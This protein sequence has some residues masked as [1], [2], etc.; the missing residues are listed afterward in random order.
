MRRAIAQAALLAA[1]CATAANAGGHFMPMRHPGSNAQTGATATNP[2]LTYYGGPILGNVKVYAVNWGSGVNSTTT[3][4]IGDFYAAITQSGLY[5][6]LAE[7]STTGQTGGTNQTLGH[8]SF[9]GSVTI[10]PS[11]SATSITDEQIQAELKAQIAAGHLATPDANSLYMINFPAGVTI[12]NAGSASCQQFCAYHSTM[13]AA[14]AG[15]NQNI[16]Y[17]VLPDLNPPSACSL[18]CGKSSNVFDNYTSVASHE[19][20][21][22]TTDAAVGLATAY[23]APLAWYDPQGSDG[24]IGDICNG[25]QATFTA[26]GGTVYTMQREWSNVAGA[27]IG[28][29]GDSFSVTLAPGTQNLAAGSTTSYQV[30]TAVTRGANQSMTLSVSGLPSGVT[31]SFSPSSITTGS[32]STL[33]LSASASAV[34]GSATFSV[35]GAGSNATSSGSATVVVSGGSG[36][37]GGGTCPS[38]SIDL[39]GVCL[40][41]GCSS[42]GSGS[43]WAAGLALGLFALLRRRKQ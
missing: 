37:T 38:G 21:E 23:A 3:S 9:A 26:S 13:A 28:A 19:L 27:C 34:N 14:T 40:P 22:A 35:T 25:E 7:Y 33:T 18:G 2:H 6:W 4:K 17:G 10:S 31:G 16:Y 43:A 5:D 39:G 11:I 41:I 20:V 36:G 24:E 42:T 1:T 30:T 8:G 29:S 12:T 15:L 32:G